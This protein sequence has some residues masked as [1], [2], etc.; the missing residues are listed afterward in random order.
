MSAEREETSTY[1]WA[2]VYV[3]RIVGL[4]AIALA[5][6][7]FALV[8]VTAIGSVPAWAGAAA[9]A[10]T[11]AVLLAGAGV[12]MR[13]PVLMAL[14][15]SGYRI[16]RVRGAGAA[17]ANW[18]SVRSVETRASWAGPAIVVELTDGSTSTLP[19]SL[20]G[21]RAAEAQH[22]MHE[23]LNAAYGYRRLDEAG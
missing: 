2:R 16:R 20:L 11:A 21:T 4:L 9:A 14:T 12:L 7:W 18:T 6:C 22:E 3:V 8:F 15:P 5:V 10:G 19:L 13:P 23:R 17:S 1:R